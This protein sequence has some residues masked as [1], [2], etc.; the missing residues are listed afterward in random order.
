[1]IPEISRG[2]G[3]QT[4]SPNA[5]LTTRTREVRGLW[6]TGWIAAM[7]RM[8]IPHGGRSAG[9]AGWAR[10][11]E[12]PGG[13]AGLGL[14]LVS[15]QPSIRVLLLF[16]QMSPCLEFLAEGLLLQDCEPLTPFRPWTTPFL[17]PSPSA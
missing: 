3:P 9:D 4:T 14:I 16:L 1:M 10:D 6:M 15:Q 7:F 2:K 5:S 13:S 11:A 8:G 12:V 17:I